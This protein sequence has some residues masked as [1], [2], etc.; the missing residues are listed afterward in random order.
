M[1]RPFSV[2]FPRLEKKKIDRVE[3]LFLTQGGEKR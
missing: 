1:A 3:Y 2:V